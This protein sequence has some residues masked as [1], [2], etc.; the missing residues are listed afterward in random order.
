MDRAQKAESIETLKGGQ[1]AL[2]AAPLAAAALSGITDT[3]G[4]FLATFAGSATSA[5]TR[6]V[7]RRVRL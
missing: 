5:S 6:P 4:D 1:M 2:L 3:P 7:S